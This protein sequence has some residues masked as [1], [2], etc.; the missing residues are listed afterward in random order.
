MGRLRTDRCENFSSLLKR[1]I[2]GTYA[3]REPIHLFRYLDEQ[4]FR[5]NK[6][7]A[8]GCRP[9]RTSPQGHHRKATDL[10]GAH[11]DGGTSNVL[12]KASLKIRRGPKRRTRR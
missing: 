5:F 1:A 12:K 9:P 11:R 6:R 3:S 10:C 2:H 8:D 7:P 4:A